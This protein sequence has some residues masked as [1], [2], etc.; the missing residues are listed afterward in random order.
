MSLPFVPGTQ[1]GP[2]AVGAVLAAVTVTC[3]AYLFAV[4]A[5]MG[6]MDSAWAMPMQMTWTSGDL[7]VVWSMWAVMMA[8]MM[9]PSATPMVLAYARTVR[10]PRSSVHGSTPFFVGGYVAVWTGFAM[11]A[12]GLQSML[13]QTALVDGMG[14]STS[15]WLAGP[16][17]LLAGTYQFTRLKHS[18]LGRC[19]TPLGFLL[20]EWRDGRGGAAVMGAHHGIL[21]VGCCWAL[22]GLLFVLGVM[23]LWWIALLAT[24]VLV[25][26]ITHND[27]VP[28][29]LG[30]VMLIGGTLV[31]IGL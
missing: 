7:V 21:C 31:L 1:R 16:V 2:W 30:A 25:E 13:H 23:N 27:A 14:A 12:T 28:R 20:S 19:R 15:R 8:A 11:V 26:K 29:V 3:W 6:S 5:A 10:S 18:M 9:L 4:N 22:M 24:G 17:L